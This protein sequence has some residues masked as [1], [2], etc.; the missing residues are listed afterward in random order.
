VKRLR[1]L[2]AGV[3]ALVALS[4]SVTAC[5]SSPFAARVN[6]QTIRQ[7]ALNI[8]LRQWSSSREY[9]NAFNSSNTSSGV[10]VAGQAPGTYS[11]TWVAGVLGGMI[12]AA[13]FRQ[14]EN[15]TGKTPSPGVE[16][17]S[18]AVN[19]ISQVGWDQFSADFRQTLVVR[20]ADESTLTP[21]TVPA[22]TLKMVYDRYAQYFFNQICTVQSSAFN[23]NDATAL[24]ASGVP[25][26]HPACYDQ[27]AFAAQP[28][29][30]QNAVLGL[31]V[32]KTAPPIPTLY[33]YLVVRVVSR[34]EQ[35]FTPDVQRVLSTAV[36]SAQGSPNPTLDGLVAKANVKV[37]PAYGSWKSS[38]VMP[39]PAPASGA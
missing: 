38:Q 5:D 13:I 3:A 15:A 10:T 32:G 18:S 7:T 33:G 29:S 25:N 12:D 19:A 11:S 37:N 30:F 35:G 8:E 16:A 22:A 26:G 28:P 6:S 4:L 24:Q 14:Q 36:L 1:N 17:A 21:T 23:Q 34:S 27:A 9:V 2:V 39:P 20:L 31:E